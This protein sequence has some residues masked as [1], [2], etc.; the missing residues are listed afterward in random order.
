MIEKTLSV[1][2]FQCNCRIL[3]C[4]RTGEALLID[5]GDEAEEILRALNG[6]KTPTG[7]ALEHGATRD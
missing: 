1:G 6:L 5:A 3:A 2:P 7:P 4:P